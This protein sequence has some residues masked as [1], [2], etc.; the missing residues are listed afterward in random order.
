MY[1]YLVSGKLCYSPCG[2]FFRN[3]LVP[4]PFCT[5]GHFIVMLSEH[6]LLTGQFQITHKDLNFIL[7]PVTS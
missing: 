2:A 6:Q 4:L 7:Q 3:L 5:P 1:N